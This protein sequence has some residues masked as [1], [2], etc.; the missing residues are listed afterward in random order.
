MHAAIAEIIIEN[1]KSDYRFETFTRE[2]S[3]KHEGIDFVPTSQS[4]DRGR[5]A[6]STAAGK[7]SHRNLICA[8]LNKDLN[9]KVEADLLRVTATSSPDRLIYCSSQKLSEEKVDEITKIIKRHVPAG[10]VLVLGA[11]Q[12]GAL[13]EKYADVFEKHYHS[14]VQAIRSTILAEPSETDATTKGLRLA[15]IAFGSDEATALRHEIL[16]NSVLEFFADGNTHTV[17]EITEVFSKDLGL[18]RPLRPEVVAKIIAVEERERTIR[19]EGDAWLITEF[20][21]QQLKSVPVQAATHLLEGR[22]IVRDHLES[23]IGQKIAD[24]QYQQLW[25]GLIDFL[26]GSLLCKWPRCNPG[27]RA[28]SYGN[29]R[30]LRRARPAISTSRRHQ[31]NS[32]CH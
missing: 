7:G 10:S 23:L 25:S 26:G 4:W 8:T 18:P 16:R 5:D 19:R 13:A 31:A 12:L 11:I 3:E 9:A 30:Y 21:R 27:R 32:V 17:R 22:Q 20:G 15:L 24:L 28:V 14:D 6:R 2:I 29:S 1:E